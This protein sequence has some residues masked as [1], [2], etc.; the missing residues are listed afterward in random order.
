MQHSKYSFLRQLRPLSNY[1]LA[2][3]N[4]E[5]LTD[6]KRELNLHLFYDI[7]VLDQA[8]SGFSLFVLISMMCSD[9]RELTKSTVA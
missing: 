9:K 4:F 1:L 2:L 8:S 3:D 5:E 7:V 6:I